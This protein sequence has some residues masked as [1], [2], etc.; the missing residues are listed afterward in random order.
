[1]KNR[2]LNSGAG[3]TTEEYDN[4]IMVLE[5]LLSQDGEFLNI[6]NEVYDVLCKMFYCESKEEASNRL[7]H[8]T[9]NHQRIKSS[10]SKQ[11]MD[12]FERLT[13]CMYYARNLD[14]GECE[15]D[16]ES[17]RLSSIKGYVVNMFTV[18]HAKYSERFKQTR[19]SYAKS[20]KSARTI[21]AQTEQFKHRK[22]KGSFHTNHYS[23]NYQPED[24]RLRNNIGLTSAETSRLIDLYSQ[25]NYESEEKE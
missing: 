19:I 16:R 7:A 17:A 9:L 18:A 8:A 21:V 12:T 24:P 14:F 11:I 2:N 20:N 6:V 10:N 1:M 5:H 3:M 25:D 23:R 13:S 15:N 22:K 4:L